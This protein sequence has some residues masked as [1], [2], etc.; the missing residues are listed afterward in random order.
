MSSP[1]TNDQVTAE[2]YERVEA[3][4]VNDFADLVAKR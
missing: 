1:E 2:D 4:A 3:M